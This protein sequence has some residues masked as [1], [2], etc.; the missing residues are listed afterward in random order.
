MKNTHQMLVFMSLLFEVTTLT[1]LVN[2]SMKASITVHERTVCMVGNSRLSP[3]D[4]LCWHADVIVAFFF[5]QNSC[6]TLLFRLV[7]WSPAKPHIQSYFTRDTHDDKR[8][9]DLPQ[10]DEDH[11]FKTELPSVES[12]SS[13]NIKRKIVFSTL[14]REL[15]RVYLEIKSCDLFVS[16][17]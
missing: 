7:L 9:L 10:R 5:F 2:K 16:F 15:G 8:H 12:V 1:A 14:G 17:L 11:A 13:T 4:L 3:A 6:S